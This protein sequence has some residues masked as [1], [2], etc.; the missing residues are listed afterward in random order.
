MPIRRGMARS[1]IINPLRG[2]CSNKDTYTS[3]EESMI[4]EQAIE[5]CH[6]DFPSRKQLPFSCKE[7]S[8]LTVSSCGAFRLHCSV[9]VEAVL[10]RESPG[11]WLSM[12]EELKLGHFCPMRQSSKGQCQLWAPIGQVRLSDRTI[13]RSLCSALL[14]CSLYLYLSQASPPINPL[15]S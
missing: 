2:T 4:Q 1:I 8:E 6:S 13:H 10:S 14:P 7:C 15:Y 5:L 11:R 9:W 12:A 3:H